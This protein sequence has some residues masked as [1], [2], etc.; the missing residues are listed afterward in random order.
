MPYIKNEEKIKFIKFINNLV[1]YI[2][3]K[4]DLNYVICELVGQYIA[5]TGVSYINMSEKIDA[6]HDAETELRRRLLDPY[7]DKKIMENGDV[8]SFK[9]IHHIMGIR[10]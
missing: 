5:Q 10:K 6:V 3:S 2:N 9:E 7:E 4:G 8:P 1:S